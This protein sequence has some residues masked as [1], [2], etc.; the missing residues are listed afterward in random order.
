M[1]VVSTQEEFT[2]GGGQ[3]CI[4]SKLKFR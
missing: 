3:G 4:M 2:K 1:N